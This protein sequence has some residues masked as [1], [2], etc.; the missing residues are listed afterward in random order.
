M[1]IVGLFELAAIL[2]SLFSS[3]SSVLTFSSLDAG[4]TKFCRVSAIDTDNSSNW[5]LAC[6]HNRTNSS[7]AVFS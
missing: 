4:F 3:S 2:A 5:Y 1:F 7:K 6:L